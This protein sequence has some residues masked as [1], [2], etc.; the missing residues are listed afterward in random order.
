M[1]KQLLE[2]N[3][4]VARCSHNGRSIKRANPRETFRRPV[5]RC[6]VTFHDYHNDFTWQLN[7][8]VE[9]LLRPKYLRRNRDDKNSLA[10]LLHSGCARHGNC[11]GGGGGHGNSRRQKQ[12]HITANTFDLIAA[13]VGGTSKCQIQ[14]QQP[15]IRDSRRQQ[16]VNEVHGY[17]DGFIFWKMSDWEMWWKCWKSTIISANGLCL[18]F[19]IS[20][21][22]SPLSWNKKNHIRVP[23][24]PVY[25]VRWSHSKHGQV[26]TAW[27]C[28]KHQNIQNGSLK[29]WTCSPQYCWWRCEQ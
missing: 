25:S 24:I 9:G 26:S 12:R 1:L 10:C 20:Y 27:L 2:S 28:K 17:L 18:T 22:S 13:G 8:I 23:H 15:L 6:C 29:Y 19:I 21:I 7:V 4:L 5:H 16:Q 11:M 14:G 3:S